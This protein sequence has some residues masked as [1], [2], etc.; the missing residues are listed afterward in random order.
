[1][2][3][4]SRQGQRDS[5]SYHVAVNHALRI[6]F[7]FAQTSLIVVTLVRQASLYGA[8]LLTQIS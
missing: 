3:N 2:N 1:M 5:K 4:P 8:S 6:S 7:L